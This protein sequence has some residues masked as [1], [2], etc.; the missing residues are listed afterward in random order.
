MNLDEYTEVTGH[1]QLPVIR[2][3]N[4]AAGGDR[5][6]CYGYTS[7]RNNFHVY[8]LGD[9][10]HLLVTGPSGQLLRHQYGEVMDA[11]ELRP[12]KRAYPERTDYAF[13][14]QMRAAEAPLNFTAFNNVAAAVEAGGRQFH[15]ILHHQAS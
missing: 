7:A 15:G 13:A 11:W 1:T 6:L 8:L 12:D 9:Q 10:I 5:T 14:Q 3:A 4:L 2:A